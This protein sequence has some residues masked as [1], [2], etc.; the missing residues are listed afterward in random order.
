MKA[1][2]YQTALAALVVFSRTAAEQVAMAREQPISKLPLELAEGHQNA[3]EIAYFRGLAC[4]FKTYQFH[5]FDTV[6]DAEELDAV[7]DFVHRLNVVMNNGSPSIW[8]FSAVEREAEWRSLRRD[9]IAALRQLGV[10]ATIGAEPID[11][12]ELVNVDDFVSTPEARRLLD[13]S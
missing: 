5:I 10:S 8:T 12:K 2:G 7:M 11:I 9:A 3:G 4:V 13:D 1:G 6:A